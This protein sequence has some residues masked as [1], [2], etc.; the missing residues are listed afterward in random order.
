MKDYKLAKTFA[1]MTRVC[2]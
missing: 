1:L 2:F